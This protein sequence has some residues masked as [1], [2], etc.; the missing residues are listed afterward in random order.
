[1]SQLF[2]TDLNNDEIYISNEESDQKI[3]EHVDHNALPKLKNNKSSKKKN[4]KNITSQFHVSID[5]QYL[6]YANKK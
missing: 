3:I 1:M 6:Q 4:M 5:N 2:A